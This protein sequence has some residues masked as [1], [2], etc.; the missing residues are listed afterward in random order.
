MESVEADLACKRRAAVLL[1][2]EVGRA[3]EEGEK[4]LAAKLRRDLAQLETSV[5]RLDQETTRDL[6]PPVMEEVERI[7]H[8][9][10]L[11]TADVILSPLSYPLE[12]ILLPPPG[13][14]LSVCVV[15][16]A[17]SLTEP[18]SLLALQLMAGRLVLV[19]SSQETPTVL[20]AT[21][22]QMNYGQSLY[23]RLSASSSVL[24]LPG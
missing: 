21:A 22:R 19:G 17:S 4:D 3:E 23:S 5:R 8:E 1:R 12:R 16:E 15:D 10:S 7:A 20:S 14:P 11:V 6:E 2:A 24:R 9:R 18:E 13:R